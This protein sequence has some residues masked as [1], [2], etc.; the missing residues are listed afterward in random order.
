MKC[1]L[2]DYITQYESN[3]LNQFIAIQQ[4]EQTAEPTYDAKGN[5]TEYVSANGNIVAQYQ[6]SAFGEI[7]SQSGESFPPRFST[8]PYCTTTGLIEYHSRKDDPTLGR[9]LSL[10]QSKKQVA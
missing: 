3:P 2:N 7:I 8:K 9:W 5:I 4:D 6:Y 10:T 1:I